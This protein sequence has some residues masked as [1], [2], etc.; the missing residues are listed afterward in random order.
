MKARLTNCWKFID[1]ETTFEV[2]LSIFCVPL[3]DIYFFWP[4]M[5]GIG[6]L[7]F[8]LEVWR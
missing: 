6:I 3:L 8:N 2:S 5:A 1:Y 7:G 4:R